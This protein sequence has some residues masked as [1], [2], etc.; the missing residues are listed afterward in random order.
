LGEYDPL[1][2]RWTAIDPK[3]QHY[4]PYVGMGN[5][6]INRVECRIHT[7]NLYNGR[8]VTGMTLIMRNYFIARVLVHGS[9]YA[10]YL[11]IYF[12]L[13]IS[14]EKSLTEFGDHVRK[15][16]PIFL[17]LLIISGLLTAILQKKAFPKYNINYAL[18]ILVFL[19]TVVISELCFF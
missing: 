5:N 4:S 8:M 2:G 9:V 12:M 13:R 18:I 16:L 14:G 15:V 3:R 6:P 17:W 10:G 11:F 7:S 1:I 19:A